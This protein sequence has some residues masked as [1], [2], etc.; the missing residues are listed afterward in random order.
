MATGPGMTTVVPDS[1]IFDLPRNAT[2]VKKTWQELRTAVKETRRMQTSLANKVPLEFTFRTILTENGPVERLYFL[3]VYGS[4]RENTL[5][6]TDISLDNSVG[7]DSQ[8]Q[9]QPMLESFQATPHLGLFSKEEQLLRERKRMGAFGI[10]SYDIDLQSGRFVFP[11][12][13]SLFTCTDSSLANQPVFP[14]EIGSQCNGIRMDAKLCPGNNNIMAF[15]NNNDLWI[16][17]IETGDE[18]RLTYQ[19]KGDGASLSEDPKSAGVASYIVQEEFDRYTGYWWQP[20]AK[21]DQDGSQT[22][23][24]LYEEVDESD[25]EILHITS[26]SGADKDVDEYR[27]PRAGTANAEC[28]LKLLEITIEADGKFGAVVD[29][30]LPEPLSNLFDW[31]PEYTVRCD[32][33]P[34]GKYVWAQLLSRNQQQIALVLIPLACFVP[35]DADLTS[36]N[37]TSTDRQIQVIYEEESDVWINVH[38]HL[39]F[40]PQTIESEISFIWSSEKTGYRHLYY[41]TASLQPC[42]NGFQDPAMETY[43]KQSST[44]KSRILKCQALTSGSSAVCCKEIWVD[45]TRQLVYYV[46]LHDTP[47]EEHLYV[48]SYINPSEP[49]RLTE[50][51]YSHTVEMSLDCNVF[52]SVFSSISC[53]PSAKVYKVSHT[54]SEI[55]SQIVGTLLE[56]AAVYNQYQPPEIFQY[57]SDSSGCTMYGLLYKPH[58]IEQGKKYP[59]VVF[60]YGGPQVQLVT[61]SYKGIKLLRLHTLASLGYVV[62]VLDGRGSYNRGLEFEAR[63]KH[64]MGTVE[65]ED[66]VEGLQWIASNT[67]CIDLSRV[68]IHGWS[69][70]GY[71]SLM[72]LAQRPDVFKVS[73]AGAPVTSWNIYDTGYTERYMDTPRNNVQGYKEGSVLHYVRSFPNE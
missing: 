15:V 43:D 51:G 18:T 24:M 69:Y 10:T 41:V 16:T 70:G 2:P 33:T 60:V 28:T 3:G 49:V 47:L 72:G 63:I 19:H 34:C 5:L 66:Q 59:T 36:R 68:A 57:K 35:L 14:D 40:F 17:N 32:W 44:L 73:I 4:G 45:E 27:Y 13:S 22:L 61:N 29:K 64:C 65:I 30:C 37:D 38:D 9:W 21:T 20:S 6:Y 55:T 50:S 26:P 71:L 1:G 7:S 12:C 52:V 23:R 11:A 67:D 39:Y 31:S 42:N 8:L 56:P 62:M 25:V 48:V 53:P 54:G 46:G 58:Q